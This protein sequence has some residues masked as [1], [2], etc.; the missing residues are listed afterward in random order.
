LRKNDIDD[1]IT[2]KLKKL[3]N[4]S[5]SHSHIFSCSNMSWN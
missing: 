2:M 1:T 3:F 4:Q 5:Q